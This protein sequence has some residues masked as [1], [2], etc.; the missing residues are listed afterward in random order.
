MFM[1]IVLSAIAMGLCFA[2]SKWAN[3]GWLKN[4][5]NTYDFT[6][7]YFLVLVSTLTWLSLAV[8]VMDR[9]SGLLDVVVFSVVSLLGLL[10][11][12]LGFLRVS[13]ALAMLT[14]CSINIFFWIFYFYYFK[15]R[16]HEFVSEYEQGRSG[17]RTLDKVQRK[18]VFWFGISA[19]IMPALYHVL[20]DSSSYQSMDILLVMVV[21]YSLLLFTLSVYKRYVL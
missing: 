11:G 1:G 14:L 16:R 17:F 15:K 21:P 7:G 12:L 18:N 19:L 20:E 10:L 5:P 13:W 3:S 2:V 9:L 4:N 6:W 8:A